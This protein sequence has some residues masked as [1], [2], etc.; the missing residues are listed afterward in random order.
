MNERQKPPDEEEGFSLLT[1]DVLLECVESVLGR[2]TSG[3]CRPYASY[4]NRVA[5]VGMAEGSSVVVK[6]YRPGRWSE[7]ALRD[8][9]EFL[10]DLAKEEIPVI[11]PLAGEEGK[12]LFSYRGLFYAIFPKFGGRMCDEPAP[13]QWQ[14]IGRLLARMHATGS[15]RI[16]RDR[17]TIH[18]LKSSSLHLD[19]ILRFGGVPASLRARYEK[20]IRELLDFIAPA[21]DGVDMHRIHGDCHRGN[22][23]WRPDEPFTLIDFDDMGVGPAVQDLWM[24]LPDHLRHSRREMDQLLEGY[25]LFRPFEDR[26]LRLIEPLRAMR[27]LHYTAWCARQRADG[28]FS[29][30]APEWGTPAFWQQEMQDLDRQ[31]QEIEDAWKD[32]EDGP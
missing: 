28:G 3:I 29:R 25:D 5:E 6:F 16:P 32:A 4:I 24:L 19:F 20:M 14:Q 1:P 30:L 13:G 10:Q 9:Q 26:W 31:R 2:R 15:T 17:V 22:I 12:T 27:F 18:P 7:D 21:F 23:L 8:E 11:V